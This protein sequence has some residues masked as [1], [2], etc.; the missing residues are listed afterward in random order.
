MS[1]SW[2]ADDVETLRATQD[3]EACHARR[4]GGAV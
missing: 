4:L 3:F 2:S 1:D